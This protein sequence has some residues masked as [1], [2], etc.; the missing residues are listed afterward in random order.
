[1]I[2]MFYCAHCPLRNAKF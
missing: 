2:K 1:M